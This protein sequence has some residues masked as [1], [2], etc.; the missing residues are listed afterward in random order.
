MIKCHLSRLMGERKLKV[1]DVARETGLHRNTITLLY[2]ETAT[3]VELDAVDQ[4]CE[5]FDCEV[6]E[7]FERVS[8]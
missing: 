8:D 3:R 2:K 7:L 5:F 1:T 6:G 4:L